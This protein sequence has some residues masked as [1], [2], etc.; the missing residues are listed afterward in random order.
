MFMVAI[1]AAAAATVVVVEIR[2]HCTILTV[3]ELLCRPG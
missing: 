2:F 1:A 3:L